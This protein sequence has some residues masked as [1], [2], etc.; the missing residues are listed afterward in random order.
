MEKK[1][2]DTLILLHSNK[3]ES[4]SLEAIRTRLVGIDY[5]QGSILFS[6]LKD[7]V[8]AI[9]I[10]VLLGGLAIDRFYIGDISIGII[11]LLVTLIIGTLTCGMLSWVWWLIDLFFITGAT[12]KNNTR[13]L[14]E[15]LP[16]SY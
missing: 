8:L 3:L 16:Y 2:A 13:K 10:S 11:K 12:R 14:L 6:N 4:E 15:Q 7:P 9:I 5:T 1:Q